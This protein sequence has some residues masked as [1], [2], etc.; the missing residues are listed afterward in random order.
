MFKTDVLNITLKMTF[1]VGGLKQALFDIV[2]HCILRGMKIQHDPKKTLVFV[3]IAIFLMICVYFVFGGAGFTLSPEDARLHAS[4]DADP[5]TGE[6]FEDLPQPSP[7]DH[8]G[9]EDHS[10]VETG[11]YFDHPLIAEFNA[12][13]L[14]PAAGKLIQKKEK[15]KV[16]LK[17]KE[18]YT[19]K[20]PNAKKP[21]RIAI[22]ID[23]MGVNRVLSKAVAQLDAP[24]TLAYLPYAENLK[25]LTE[26][27]KQSGHE[28]IIH[29]PMEPMDGKIDTGPIVVKDGMKR[30]DVKAMME[31]AFASFDGYT[32]INNH[33]GSRATQDPELMSWVMDE[34]R[35]KDLFYV[36]SKTISTSV[37]ADA[38]KAYGLDY[39]E[40]DVFLDHEE[41][42]AFVM[43]ALEKTEKVALQRGYA[44][45]IGHPKDVTIKGLKEWIPTLKARGFEIVPVSEL[46][47]TPQIQKAEAEILLEAPVTKNSSNGL[48]DLPHSKPVTLQ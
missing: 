6:G 16:T 43:S 25:S 13:A 47:M 46:L 11:V 35:K 20:N 45:A 36:D 38:A 14:E 41:S 42:D 44:I 7:V 15:Q 30:N 18:Q 40:R 10:K 12:D 27:A 3:S 39:A 19:L 5:I 22:I 32:G 4:K 1:M 48:Y 9:S 2:N 37:A 34:L 29:M 26:P 28:L 24:L 23:D 17:P 21:A 31:K 8:I 33:M